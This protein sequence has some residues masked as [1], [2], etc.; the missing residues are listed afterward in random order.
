MNKCNFCAYS[1]PTGVAG[2]WEC[3]MPL[4]RVVECQQAIYRM[5]E[6]NEKRS[7]NNNKENK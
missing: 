1:V 7:N 6:Y 4:K 2:V 3:K 5:M